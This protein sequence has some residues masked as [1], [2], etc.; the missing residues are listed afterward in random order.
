MTGENLE[1]EA[2]LMQFLSEPEQGL[3]SLVRYIRL[4]PQYSNDLMN[5]VDDLQATEDPLV[6]ET[7]ELTEERISSVVS[8]LFGSTTHTRK[9]LFELTQND[10]MAAATRLNV[11]KNVLRHIRSGRADLAT[12]PA[13]FM[14]AFADVVSLPL[15][16]LIQELNA[17][18]AVRLS[19]KSDLPPQPANEKLSFDVLMASCGATQEQQAAWQD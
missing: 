7:T 8:T 3:E 17:P 9:N 11:P 1:R 16:Q 15:E 18:R 4:Y 6:S 12:I 19:Y 13:R 10:L 2:V 14:K 5:I